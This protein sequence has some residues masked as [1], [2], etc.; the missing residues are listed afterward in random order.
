MP[1]I[2]LRPRPTIELPV[3]RPL[4]LVS[5][6]WTR[7][8]DPRVS[9]AHASLV[10]AARTA[11][12]EV[13]EFCYRV[14]DPAFD[15]RRV[16]HDV[17]ERFPVSDSRG[18]DLGIGAYVW[19]EAHVQ[20]ILPALRQRGWRGRI[21]LGGPQ[22]SYATGHLDR[23][24]PDADVFIRGYG[25][26]ALVAVAR[27]LGYPTVVGVHYRGRSFSDESARVDL[28]QLPSPFLHGFLPVEMD[29]AFLR[30]ETQRGC[31]FRCSFCQHR[32]AGRRLRRREL[33]TSRIMAEVDLFVARRVRDIAVLDPIFNTATRRSGRDST[34]PRSTDIL[35]RFAERGFTGRLSLQCRFEFLDEGFLDACDALDVRLEFGLQT[36]HRAEQQ[37]IARRNHLARVDQAIAELRARDISF[38]VS[39]IYGL[40]EQTRASFEASVDWC[41]ARGVPVIKAFPLM[42]LRGT[43]LERDRDRWHLRE[44][45]EPIPAVIASDSFTTADWQYMRSLSL[46]LQQT[47]GSHP[48][49]VAQL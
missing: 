33:A 29:Q 38:E 49:S 10:A 25:E 35:R 9:L 11:D 12:I 3:H 46:A 17:L 39:L 26:N 14:D 48:G 6:D 27:S 41:L 19:N 30:W 15:W 34:T 43:A 32:E 20:A 45:N 42:L 40:P 47:E 28:E 37:A 5:L 4:G 44:N 16:V 8:K 1:L 23:F 13:V 31:P 2:R 24:Y 36:I 18:C 21:I 7:P 22:V